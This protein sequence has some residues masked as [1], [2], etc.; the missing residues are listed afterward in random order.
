MRYSLLVCGILSLSCLLITKVTA[1]PKGIAA[2]DCHNKT[3]HLF[4]MGIQVKNQ[5]FTYGSTNK[6]ADD[7]IVKVM[8]SNNSTHKWMIWIN[9]ESMGSMKQMSMQSNHSDHLLVIRKTAAHLTVSVFIKPKDKDKGEDEDEDED[10]EEEVHEV[11]H[12][13]NNISS[14]ISRVY[15]TST[16]EL[17]KIMKLESPLKLTFEIHGDETLTMQTKSLLLFN[18]GPVGGDDGDNGQVLPATPRTK[19]GKKKPLSAGW[20]VGISVAVLVAV[21]ILGG[22]IYYTTRRRGGKASGRTLRRDPFSVSSESD[23]FH[24]QSHSEA[25]DKH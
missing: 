19:K 9:K 24:S 22:A 12:L 8:R 17:G 5:T 1:E 10:E 20:I 2:A 25:D 3:L 13:V 23:S 18:G 14:Q 7:V 16:A 15:F 4:C 21:I 6:S 11:P